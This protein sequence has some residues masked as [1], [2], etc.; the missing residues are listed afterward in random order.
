MS[1][2]PLYDEGTGR[3]SA[4]KATGD[5]AYVVSQNITGKF[6]EAFE[7][8]DPSNGNWVEDKATGDYVH[9]DG[10]ALASSYL[11]ISKSPYNAGTSTVIAAK[12]MT[13][14]MPIEAAVGLSMS[15]RTLGQEFSIEL[16]D[17]NP[18]FSPIPDLEIASIT[19]ATTV[20]TVTTVLSHNL[21]V[22]KSIGIWNC[23]NTLANYPALVVAT[24][25][26]PTQFTC[27]AGPGGTIPSQTITNPAG[28]KGF[29]FFRERLGRA[30]N[31]ISQIFE[32]S[33]VTNASF[34]TRSEA[35]D[36]YPSGTVAGN[37]A[38]TVGTTASVALATAPYTYAWSPTTEF[39]LLCQADRVQWYDA[40]V[41]SITQP[42]NRL[43]RTQVVPDPS[44]EYSLRIR[45]TNNKSLTI[46][47]AKVVSV[48]KSGS[49]TGT[50][51]TATPHG[52]ATGDTIN[53]YGSSDNVA[54]NFPSLVVATAVTVTGPTTF[55]AVIGSGTTGTAYGGY[56]AKVQ[57]GNLM[58]ALGAVAQT[59]INATLST[60]SDGVRQL[61]L[62]GNGNWG[63]ISIGDGVEVVGVTNNT[64]GTSLGVDGTWKVANIATTAL[65]LVPYP[66]NVPPADFV[67]TNSGGAV[68]KRTEMRISYF[69]IFDFERERVELISRPAADL[70]G[71]VPV[72]LQGGTV[73]TVAAVTTV[74]TV[75]A[76]TAITGAGTPAVPATPYF[77]NSLATTN[78]AL[79]LTGTSGLAAFWATNTGAGA[80][81]VKLYNKATAPTVGTD[82]PE[83]I[84][85]VPAA[86]GG[87][88]GVASLPMGFNAFRFALG[89]GIAITGGAAD[90]DTTA[91]TAG[92]VKVKLSRTV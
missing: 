52:L 25:V 66:G 67:L 41:D 43:L 28:V 16:V 51:T 69:R 23:S 5:A 79:I 59:A 46:I 30:N 75:S 33:T 14:S 6:R 26:S 17:N 90:S 35:G 8:Y 45:A 55:T 19:Q 9:V 36:A 82:V 27:T 48:A 73:T 61:V 21:S 84:I 40:P 86:A 31:G 53:Y 68:V 22:G 91:V 24:V 3:V 39:R 50:F 44:A 10:N 58:S 71:A 57:A 88:P 37:H 2:A 70:S 20:L 80:A 78:G 34:Y 56:I 47:D 1:F 49:T 13:I 83:M 63:G 64:N 11:V 76:V 62:T 4:W 77:V 85:P 15:Q 87:V 89:L 7:S 54:A 12:G 81:Y 74:S 72:V 32:N 29:V 92:Q 60:L 65:T 38:V 42:T 18:F